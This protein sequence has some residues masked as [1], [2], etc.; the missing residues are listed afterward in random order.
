MDAWKATKSST[1]KRRRLKKSFV[2]KDINVEVVDIGEDEDVDPNV[3]V[4]AEKRRKEVHVERS[5]RSSAYKSGSPAGIKQKHINVKKKN[6][7]LRDLVSRREKMETRN[8]I[9]SLKEGKKTRKK[10]L[11]PGKQERKC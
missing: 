6:K 4:A 1:T 3:V 11:C 10:S 5:T 2:V 7:S 9:V 8:Q